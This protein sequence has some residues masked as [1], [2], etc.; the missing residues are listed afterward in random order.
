MSVTDD[1]V[2]EIVEWCEGELHTKELS[3]EVM[4]DY[5]RESTVMT[6]LIDEIA[7]KL[8]KKGITVGA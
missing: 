1:I 7:E 3:R 6:S 4:Y 2:G 5:I 8:K